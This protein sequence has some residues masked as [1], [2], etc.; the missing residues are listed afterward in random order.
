MPVSVPFV[1]FEARVDAIDR[2]LDAGG[3]AVDRGERFDERVLPAT[4]FRRRGR[5]DDSGH[6]A[7]LR[8]DLLRVASVL[9]EDVERL[10]H[11]GGDP[12][13]GELVA[14]R[15]RRAGAGE[16]LHLRLA[17]VQLRSQAREHG[18]DRDADSRDRDRAPEHEARPAAPGAVFGMAA[19]RSRRRGITRTRLTLVPSTASIAGSKRER[20]EH[21][22]DRDQHAADAHRAEQRQR[23][24]DHRE[25]PDRHGRAGDDHRVA[26]VG[27]RLDERRLDV[28]PLAELVAE[29]EDH[30]QRVVD[31]D[32]EADQRD[33]ELHD[34][35]DV[36]DVGQRPDEREGVEDRRDRDDERHQHCGQRPEDE[37]QDDS[38]PSP[39][40]SASSRTLEPPLEPCLVASSSGW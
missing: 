22:D 10:D 36:G 20:G 39:P 17:R 35:R 24:D 9:D 28:V 23:Q 33:Q 40:I 7:Q 13:R 11:A 21:R 38:A 1:P 8:R 34:D 19:C 2:R 4:P 5:A 16:V 32:A 14:T 15:D 26:G 30:Q 27:H 3:G 6:R 25:E 29:A 31:R 37:E 12:C 18:N